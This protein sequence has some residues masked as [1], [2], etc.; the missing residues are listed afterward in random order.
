MLGVDG[1]LVFPD[2]SLISLGSSRSR[3][4]CTATLPAFARSLHRNCGL[5]VDDL[6]DVAY[7][8]SSFPISRPL[9][10]PPTSLT[11]PP[12]T[13]AQTKGP[14]LWWQQECILNSCP[15]TER[16]NAILSMLSGRFVAIK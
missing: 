11:T 14:L 16:T 4:P 13:S 1:G 8:F 2:V 10:V 12:L 5:P 3:P 15:D 7:E 9:G 6:H